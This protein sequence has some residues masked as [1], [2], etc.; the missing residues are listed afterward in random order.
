ML[1]YGDIATDVKPRRGTT[2]LNRRV[3]RPHASSPRRSSNG[4]TRTTLTCVVWLPL[5]SPALW[6]LRCPVSRT[7]KGVS[8]TILEALK[9]CPARAH[10]VAVAPEKD[11]DAT[12]AV[13]RILPRQL[14][15]PL[16]HGRVAGRLAAL[17]AQCRSR[18]LIFIPNC[19]E[20][21][22]SWPTSALERCAH[23]S[24]DHCTF[25]Q[26]MSRWNS[27]RM[28][29]GSASFDIKQRAG[30]PRR[31]TA[32]P[33]I[34]NLPPTGRHAH[35]FFAATSFM[36][37]ISR[38]RSAASFFSRAFSASSC[39]RRLMSIR[40]KA[41]KTLAPCVDRLLADPVPLGHHRRLDSPV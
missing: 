13:A 18:H 27:R 24:L 41:T 5:R 38:S 29:S 14:L 40:L 22:S 34:R 32:L 21:D 30:P 26:W 33:A 25:L 4:E 23:I 20:L 28:S 31:E 17:V 39:F 1:K 11:A 36:T 12:I 10:A 3:L 6:S 16:H 37:S 7:A 35:Q 15:H 19:G 2:R 8:R 9:L